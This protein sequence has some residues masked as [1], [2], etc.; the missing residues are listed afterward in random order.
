MAIITLTVGDPGQVGEFP[1]VNKLVTSD[2]LSVI[3]TAGY[4]NNSNTSG[5]PIAPTDIF[6]VVYNY[7]PTSTFSAGS[8]FGNGT[9]GRF[10][11]IFVNGVITLQL[12]NS[13]LVWKDITVS[14]ASL[15]SGGQV[16]VQDSSGIQQFKVRDIRM[17]YSASGLSGGGGNRLLTLTDGTT[18]FNNAGI[19]AALLGT[20]VNTLW[21]GSGNPIPGTVSMQTPTAAGADLYFNYSGGTTDFSTGSI[22]VSVLVERIA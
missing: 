17:N 3:T 8:G 2:S 19:T 21:G 6:D 20:P 22:V 1:R 11:P 14:A 4:L 15:A 12:Q 18:V 7:S 5:K 13:N 10:V 9:Y 16:L